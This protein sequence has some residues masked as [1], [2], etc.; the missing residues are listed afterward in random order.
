[1]DEAM[2]GDKPS[3]AA[4]AVERNV[5][6]P[7]LEELKTKVLTT[8]ELQAAILKLVELHNTQGILM[9]AAIQ[10]LRRYR[11]SRREVDLMNTPYGL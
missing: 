8:D 5:R 2:N 3:G 6:A 9:D 4:S 1:M 10:D 7:T 11:E